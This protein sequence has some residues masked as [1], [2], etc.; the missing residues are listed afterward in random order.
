MI[1]IAHKIYLRNIIKDRVS[2]NKK[3]IQQCHCIIT[4]FLILLPKVVLS[5]YESDAMQV[6]PIGNFVLAPSQRPG[7]LF[8]FGQNVIDRNNILASE[9]AALLLGHH[10]RFFVNALTFLYGVTDSFSFLITVPAPVINKED[11]LHASGFGDINFQAEYEFY[12][13]VSPTS[14]TQATVL[15]TLFLP[16]GV[17]DAIQTFEEIPQLATGLGSTSFFAGTTFNRTTIEWYIYASTGILT[18]LKKNN[19]KLGNSFLYQGGFG[20][21]L[22]HFEDKILMLMFEV[23]GI[24][25]KPN[26]FMGINIGNTGGTI[27]FAGPSVWYSTPTFIFQAGFQVP[28]F[29]KLSGIQNKTSFLCALSLTWKSR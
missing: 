27:I 29:Q 8:S 14:I 21:N 16:T 22:G 1:F 20:K 28:L 4:F 19:S 10:K 23:S 9:T 17:F 24:T 3:L 12:E 15:G 11:H 25:S 26:K 6:M 7:A 5:S 2:M 13:K 18:T